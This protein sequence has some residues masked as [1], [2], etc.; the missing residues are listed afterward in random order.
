MNCVKTIYTRSIYLLATMYVATRLYDIKHC[1]FNG[2]FSF[3]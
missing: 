1:M 3:L 2:I